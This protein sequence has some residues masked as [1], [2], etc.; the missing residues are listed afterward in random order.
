MVG[1]GGEPLL[2]FSLTSNPKATM[3][4]DSDVLPPLDREVIEALE[5]FFPLE[6]NNLIARG[7]DNDNGVDEYLG[8]SRC[9][10]FMGVHIVWACSSNFLCADERMVVPLDEK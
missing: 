9:V 6:C 10:Y 2:S 4:V 7:R 5:C 3:R 1:A 8:K